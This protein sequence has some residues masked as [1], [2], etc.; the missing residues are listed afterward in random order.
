M[1]PIVAQIAPNEEQLPAVLERGRDVVVTAGAGTGKT[2]TLVARYL[3]LL[4]EGVPLRS[5]V[6]ITFT[7][8]AAREMRNRIRAEM[9]SYLAQPDLAHEERRIWDEHYSQLDAA[10]IGTIHNLCTEILRAHPAEMKLDPRFDV[11]DEGLAGILLQESVDEALARAVDD[12][13][14]VELFTFLGEWNLRSLL[15]RLMARRPEARAALSDLPD[16]LWPAWEAQIVKPIRDYLGDPEVTAG[17]SDLVSLKTNGTLARATAQGDALA[18]PLS[19]LLTLWDQ[20]QPGQARGDWLAVGSLLGPLRDNMKLVGRQASWAPADPKA[21][22]KELRATYDEQL[23]GIVGQGINLALDLQMATLMP[24]LDTTFTWAIDAY[25]RRK[26]ERQ[27]LDFDDLEE[28]ALRLLAEHPDGR[29]RWQREVSAILVDEYQ[30]TNDRQ[31]VLVNLING[32]GGKLFIVGDAKQSIYRFRGAE[33]AVFRD[34]RGRIEA[35][36]GASYDLSQSYRAHDKLVQG[37]NDLLRPILGETEDPERPWREP[38]APLRHYREEPLEGIETPFIEI[39]LTVGSKGDGALRRAATALADHLVRLVEREGSA[40]RYGDI[41]ILCRASTSFGAYED[42]LDEAGLPYLTV[43]GRGF[44]DRPEVR[45]LLNALKALADPTDDLAL[46]G[47]LRSPVMGFSDGELYDL[48]LRGEKEDQHLALWHVLQR[49]P[50]ERAGRAVAL[51]HDL[52]QRA[53]RISAA[54]LL[55]EFLDATDYRGGLLQAG[56]PRAARNVSKLLADTQ[57]SGIVSA[58]EFLEYVAGLRAGAV[59]EGEARA[60]AGNVIRLMSVH[61][62][63][64]LEFPV[65]VIGDINYAR[66]GQDDLLLEPGLGI[67]PRLHDEEGAGSAM[68]NLRQ[69]KASDQEAAESDRLLYVAATRARDK[70]ILNGCCKLTKAQ[71]LGWLGGWLKQLSEPSGLASQTIDHDEEGGR[72]TVI[73]LRVGQTAVGCTVYEPGFGGSR[74]S[75]QPGEEE[76]LSESWEPILLEPYSPGRRELDEATREREEEPQRMVW[77]IVPATPRPGAPAW[78]VGKL[79]HEALAGWRFPGADFDEWAE[80]RAQSYGL[81]DSTRVADAVRETRRLMARFRDH[82]LFLEMD[83]AEAR[84]H[85]IPYDRPGGNG[86]PEH[87]IIDVLCRRDGRWMVVDF[88]TDRI[89]DEGQLN[90]V[91]REKKYRAQMARYVA[92][93]ETLLGERPLARLCFL[94]YQGG[95]KIVGDADGRGLAG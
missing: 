72:A 12:T 63:K 50:G 7:R 56:Y 1:H 9:Q 84:H 80:S 75:M 8:K 29:R 13:A 62:A 71:K 44:Y 3:S 24:A 36:G 60:T 94:N 5:I 23:R 33:V 46:V 28:M 30:D 11:L 17:F 58:E 78:L 81:V 49:D 51:I 89:L 77:R 41:A 40:V 61:A 25:R 76:A 85:E 21:I 79:V 6:A 15:L 54:D 16:P 93:V 66:P 57:T 88:K 64:G 2:R 14:T 38:F 59:R 31:R 83:A 87:G 91:L 35:D 4:A 26:E 10:R 22:L 47:L 42:A 45:D 74:S 55:K 53:G 82:E 19:E 69:E 95:V 86:Q 34:E 73:D 18:G 37:L 27:A 70:L 68:F 52:H 65:V 48:V 90:Y 67:L 20:I 39:Q 43:A 32:E 92:A